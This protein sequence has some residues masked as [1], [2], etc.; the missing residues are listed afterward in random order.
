MTD[1]DVRVMKILGRVDGKPHRLD[2][3]YVMDY[4]PD[5]RAD[6]TVKLAATPSVHQAKRFASAHEALECWRAVAAPPHHRRRWDG[7][8]NR[9]LTMFTVA[10]LTEAGEEA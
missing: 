6:G 2:G 5:V 1:S 8:P 9:P 10:I 3:L 7:K 4:C